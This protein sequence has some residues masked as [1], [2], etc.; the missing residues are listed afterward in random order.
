MIK[1]LRFC[2]SQLRL[3]QFCLVLVCLSADWAGAL[4]HLTDFANLLGFNS[5]V[6]YLCVCP[7]TMQTRAPEKVT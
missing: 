5:V 1:F 4:V 2:L 3:Q 7:Q 6:S